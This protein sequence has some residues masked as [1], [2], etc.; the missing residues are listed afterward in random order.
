MVLQF[1]KGLFDVAIHRKHTGSI[2]VVPLKVDANVLFCLCI[3]FDGI[4]LAHG[5]H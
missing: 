5:C 1:A 2:I 4:M 3:V